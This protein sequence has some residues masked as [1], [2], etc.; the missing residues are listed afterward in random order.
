VAGTNHDHIFVP[1][2]QAD[3]AMRELRAL[4]AGQGRTE[5]G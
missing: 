2:A 3:A 4:Q 5:M 1:L